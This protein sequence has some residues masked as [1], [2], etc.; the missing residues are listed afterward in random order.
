M[1]IDADIISIQQLQQRERA[2]NDMK[3]LEH[4]FGVMWALKQSDAVLSGNKLFTECA[5]LCLKKEKE[6]MRVISID[7]SIGKELE[8]SICC[9]S[10]IS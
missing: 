4:F 9:R 7:S 8:H 2:E 1:Q 6:V 5:D 3:Q 10:V